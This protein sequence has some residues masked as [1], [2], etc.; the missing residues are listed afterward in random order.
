MSGTWIEPVKSWTTALVTVPDLNEEIRDRFNLLKTQIADD[1]TINAGSRRAFRGLQLRTEQDAAGAL[2]KVIL[3]RADEIQMSDGTRVSDWDALTASSAAAAAGGIDTGAI[4]ASK[5][6][7]VHAIRKRSD[8]T[9][10]IVLRVADDYS[11]DQSYAATGSNA[12]LRSAAATA[13]VGQGF[14]VATSGRLVAIDVQLRRVNTPTGLVWMEIQGDNGGG[15]PN[16]TVLATSVKLPV[17]GL[18]S[19]EGRTRFVF[20]EALSLVAGIQHHFVLNSNVALDG[21]NFLQL[22]GTGTGGYANGQT[23]FYDSGAGTWSAAGGVVAD[24]ELYVY[25]RR[26]GAA[27]VMPAGYDQSCKLGYVYSDS[28]ALFRAFAQFDRNVRNLAAPL[29]SGAFTGT[30]GGTAGAALIDLSTVLPPVPV[31]AQLQTAN[32][33]AAGTTAVVPVSEYNAPSGAFRVTV[34]VADINA[35]GPLLADLPIETQAVYG[36]VPSGGGSGQFW[37]VGWRIL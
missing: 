25:V 5:W 11:L 7:E 36:I 32:S 6:Y 10:A 14:K 20:H 35:M 3:V 2:T 19:P 34:P 16:N 4:Q 27:L 23:T 22:R 37:T 12:T 18:S 31:V 17:A 26:V 13:K 24:L 8:G 30:W 28:S 9:K 29:A 33:V 1:G 21:T 15:L